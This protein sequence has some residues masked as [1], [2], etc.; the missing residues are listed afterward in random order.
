VL[1]AEA[2][3]FSAAS[4]RPA[5]SY[6]NS[7][8]TS[9]I[10]AATV[11]ELISIAKNLFDLIDRILNTKLMK[12]YFTTFSHGPSLPQEVR[13]APK[14][15]KPAGIIVQDKNGSKIIFWPEL[16]GEL[17]RKLL[18]QVCLNPDKFQ[19]AVQDHHG[20]KEWIVKILDEQGNGYAYLWFGINPDDGWKEDGL[21]R[22][23]GNREPHV[24]QV[25]QR[26]SNG[27]YHRLPS[28]YRAIEKAF[29]QSGV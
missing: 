6:L 2:D 29:D 17:Q 7:F 28:R 16:R 23:G 24:W 14:D 26:Y 19:C 25:Y 15:G 27:S 1:T 8:Q 18:P 3:R 22:V 5:P 21:I 9:R 10:L 13:W 20:K 4:R 11:L 12:S